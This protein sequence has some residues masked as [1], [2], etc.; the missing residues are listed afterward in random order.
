MAR[1]LLPPRGVN[2]PTRMI[3]DPQLPPALILTWIQLRGLAW[4]GTVTPPLRMQELAALTG[5]CQATIYRST[6]RFHPRVT[7][8][9][10]RVGQA[11][12]SSS[13]KPRPVRQ[14]RLRCDC[15]Q[16]AVTVLSVRVG[17]DPQYIVHLPLCPNC[18]K[19][20]QRFRNEG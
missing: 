13:H 17:S 5:K 12:R 6:Y 14:R 8:Q 9:V 4:G 16:P 10:G 1:P 7:N 19:L 20:E 3:Y 2:V 18:L 11:K 15:G